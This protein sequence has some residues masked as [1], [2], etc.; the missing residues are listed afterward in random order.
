MNKNNP[1]YKFKESNQ[2]SRSLPRLTFGQKEYI[3]SILQK[4]LSY[5]LLVEDALGKFKSLDS[6]TPVEAVE[7]SRFGAYI[8]NQPT[9]W[10]RGKL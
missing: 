10:W 1:N 3:K 5:E 7:I 9:T 2:R 8:L 6:L 4:G